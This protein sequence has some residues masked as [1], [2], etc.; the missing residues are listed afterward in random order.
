[1][2]GFTAVAHVAGKQQVALLID[3]GRFGGGGACVQTQE[4]LAGVIRQAALAYRPVMA[5]A[6][7]LQLLL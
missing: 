2:Q 7:L 5:R 4:A 3:Q 1:M 6:E